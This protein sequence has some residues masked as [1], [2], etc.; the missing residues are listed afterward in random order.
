MPQSDKEPK[1][2]KFSGLDSCDEVDK[3][4]ILEPVD[5]SSQIAVQK[6]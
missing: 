1:K 6:I 5:C 4:D 3:G 2:L